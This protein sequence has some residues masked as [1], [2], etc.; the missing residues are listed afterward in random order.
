[1]RFFIFFYVATM[2]QHFCKKIVILLS[3][4]EHV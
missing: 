2:Q 1:M 3:Q 4:I